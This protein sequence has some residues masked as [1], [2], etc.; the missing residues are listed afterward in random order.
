MQDTKVGKI[1]D[2]MIKT[3][4][5]VPQY[6]KPFKSGQQ[7]ATIEHF[8]MKKKGQHVGSTLK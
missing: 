3:F 6:T 1:S 5:F 2:I 8:R 4:F 7:K